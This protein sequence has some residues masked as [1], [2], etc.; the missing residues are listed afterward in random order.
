M[1]KQFCCL[2]FVIK[3]LSTI[4][5]GIDACLKKQVSRYNKDYS[6][7]MHYMGTKKRLP[8]LK[9]EAERAFRGIM[10]LGV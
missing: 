2:K 8:Q 7:Q 5:N 6:G 10:E 9:E 1:N 4:E 3:R